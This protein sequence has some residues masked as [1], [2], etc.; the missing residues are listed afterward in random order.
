[1]KS[2]FMNRRRQKLVSIRGEEKGK[3]CGR[4]RKG[5]VMC[6]VHDRSID[7]IREESTRL[8][9][10]WLKRQTTTFRGKEWSEVIGRTLPGGGKRR[11]KKQAEEKD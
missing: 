9:C 5:E 2:V 8:R 4:V 6:Q 1:M 3:A 10:V 11:E 7:L